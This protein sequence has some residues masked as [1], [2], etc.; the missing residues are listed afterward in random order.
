MSADT[1]WYRNIVP[2][3]LLVLLLCLA[4]HRTTRLVTRDVVPLG[5]AREW[6]AQ[7]WGTYVDAPDR[8]TAIGGRRTYWPMRSLAYLWECDWCASMWVG[9]MLTYLTWRWT[10]L[11]TEHWYVSVLVWLTASTVT[12]LLA[13]REP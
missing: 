8:R 12:G 10:A 13:Q 2:M 5:A 6:F 11:G 7:R 1:S 9:M 3:W 4:T